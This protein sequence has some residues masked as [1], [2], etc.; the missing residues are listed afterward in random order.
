MNSRLMLIFKKRSRNKI[1][2]DLNNIFLYISPMTE[3]KNFK[4]GGKL[5]TNTWY[6]ILYRHVLYI[7]KSIWNACT[8]SCQAKLI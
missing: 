2:I 8:N 3:P 1:S 7:K 5:L 4:R 6:Y